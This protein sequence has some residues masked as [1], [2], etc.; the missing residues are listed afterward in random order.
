MFNLIEK[1]TSKLYEIKKYM[2]VKK[3]QKQLASTVF[4]KIIYSKLKR[5]VRLDQRNNKL[6]FKLVKSRS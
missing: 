1:I 6:I 2:Q 3:F 4:K 5:Y